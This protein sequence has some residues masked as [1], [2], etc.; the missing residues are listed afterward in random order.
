M[1]FDGWNNTGT[2][3][4]LICNIHDLAGNLGE[5]T[6]EYSTYIQE[7][8]WF[9]SWFY[10]VTSRGCSHGSAEPGVRIDG[11]LDK[12]WPSSAGYFTG[13]RAVLYVK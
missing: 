7:G 5:V 12:W 1:S 8:V 4:D 2:G 11:P 3:T 13:F 9:D 10:P 6:T